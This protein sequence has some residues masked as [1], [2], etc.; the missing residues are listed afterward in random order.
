MISAINSEIIPE[1]WYNVIPDLPEP[2][3]PPKDSKAEFSS[4][5]LLNKILPKEVLRQ[6]F[7]FKRYEKIPDEVI[8][9]YEQIGRPT[10]LIRAKTW[11]SIWIMA[12]RYFT[13][14]RA[15]RPQVHI[16]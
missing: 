16:R 11:K 8:E 9:Q 1:N 10:P 13:N 15:P 7:T 6:E 2:L 12:G 4:I 14:L 5:N 3:P